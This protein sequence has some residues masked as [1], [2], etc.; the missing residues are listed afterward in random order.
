MADPQIAQT[1][2]SL[3]EL[4]DHL[5]HHLRRRVLVKLSRANPRG[6]DE[7]TTS[8]FTKDDEDLELD[9]FHRHLP[10]LDGAGFINWDREADIITRGP[11]FEEIAPLVRLM[12]GH[13]DEL[14]NGWPSMV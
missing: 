1:D 9:L 3:T 14:P 12:D 10:K 13:A 2:P 8:E 11:R 5:G 4:F 6:R 7:F